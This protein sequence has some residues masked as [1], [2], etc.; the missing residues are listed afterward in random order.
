[1]SQTA[2]TLC[3]DG[4][5]IS[6]RCRSTYRQRTIRSARLVYCTRGRSSTLRLLELCGG[7]SV[8]LSCSSEPVAELTRHPRL[9]SFSLGRPFRVDS[10]ELTIKPPGSSTPLGSV[11]L[12]TTAPILYNS[13]AIQRT[14][15]G[16]NDIAELV[17]SQWVALC[18]ELAPLVRVLYGCAKISKTSLQQLS[19][20]T[21]TRVLNWPN[22]ISS[23]I[24]VF[25]D[26][27]T[28]PEVLLLHM[29]YHNFLLLIH[30]PWTSKGSHPRGKIGPGYRH[31][32]EVCRTSASEVAS[33]VRQHETAHGLRTLH[34][35][36]VTII[37]SASLILIFGL[38]AEE[39]QDEGEKQTAAR[40]LNTC[41]RALDKLGQC[42]ES[43]KHAHEHL[44]AIQ[45]HW[46]Q[47]RRDAKMGG[48]NLGPAKR[49]IQGDNW[50]ES[51]GSASK[52]SRPP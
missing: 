32:R 15:E 6:F 19:M 43:A 36:A 52:K 33:L 26:Q 24:R 17:A 48:T 14:S 8:S 42:F 41:F 20:Q 18:D 39:W 37:A 29:A 4:D 45:K 35:Y 47:K 27:K 11:P 34:V 46:A 22:Q 10:E 23:S 3:R 16:S 30:R 51:S 12:G 9:W 49:K 1:M 13:S 38:I 21:S 25:P 28:A 5:A 50:K 2:L 44:L 7:Q 40:N 31:A